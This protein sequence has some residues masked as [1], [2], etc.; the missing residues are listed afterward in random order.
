[1]GDV[2]L[3]SQLLDS[4]LHFVT[5]EDKLKES[6]RRMSLKNKKKEYHEAVDNAVTDDDFA[7][8]KQLADEL[9]DT[10]YKP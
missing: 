9:R 5:D 7:H 10:A 1:M 2:G 6:L 4:I 8:L 3:V